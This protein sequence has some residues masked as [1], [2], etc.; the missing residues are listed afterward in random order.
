MRGIL[1]SLC[2]VA[3]GCH[4]F[5]G[6]AAPSPSS[7]DAAGVVDGARRDAGGVR[8]RHDAGAAPEISVQD[9]AAREV[10]VVRDA[11]RD[12][13]PPCGGSNQCVPDPPSGWSGPV[14]V[15]EQPYSPAAAAPCGGGA[16]YYAQP[17]PQ[18]SCSKCACGHSGYSCSPA[19]VQCWFGNDECQGSPVD[20]TKDFS[21]P[22]TCH[23]VGSYGQT[24]G[25]KIGGAS[26]SNV[27]MCKADGGG[28]IL[29]DPFGSQ[30]D[31]C[32]LATAAGGCQK[33]MQCVP[34]PGSADLCVWQ[35]GTQPACPAGPFSKRRVVHAGFT[36]DRMCSQC[37][38]SAPTLT[39]NGGS[40]TV[41]GCSTSCGSST[42]GSIPNNPTTLTSTNGCQKLSM[43]IGVPSVWSV[44]PAP[45]VP[46]IGGCQLLSDAQPQGSLTPTGPVT[47]CCM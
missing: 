15:D 9:A 2:A 23:A 34:S 45:R 19:P 33:G 17:K 6:H 41:Y 1:L 25:C 39:C 30:L 4:S 32:P 46:S 36:S 35:G 3:C 27:G 11:A 24:V 37:K 38:C 20:K 16:R 22:I 29:G 44:A 14:T 42:C 7:T 47:L 5:F 28:A 26:Y 12:K 21:V 8:D 18:F 10:T 13:L 43:L 40:Y 31:A